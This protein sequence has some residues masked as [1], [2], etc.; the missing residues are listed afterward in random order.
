MPTWVKGPETRVPPIVT[1]PAEA[2]I[3]PATHIIKVLLPQPDGPTI[4]TN[5]PSAIATSMFSSAVTSP[6]AVVKVLPRFS[7]R[8]MPVRG[9]R[10]AGPPPLRAYF[11][12]GMNSLV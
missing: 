4:E 8:I 11:G 12:S 3:S 10:A 2:S 1:E 7:I 9:L 6:S 5:S